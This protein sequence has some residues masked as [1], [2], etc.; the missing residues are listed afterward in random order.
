M[1]IRSPLIGTWGDVPSSLINLIYQASSQIPEGWAPA[2]LKNSTQKLRITNYA[3]RLIFLEGSVTALP[4]NFVVKQPH[5]EL[6][7]LH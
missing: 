7:T 6:S 4:K 3:L 1:K 2:Q 5:L